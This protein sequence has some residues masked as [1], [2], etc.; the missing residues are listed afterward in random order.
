[1]QIVASRLKI[2]VAP[3][4]RVVVPEEQADDLRRDDLALNLIKRHWEVDPKQKTLFNRLRA[5]VRVMLFLVV[6]LGFAAFN[7]LWVPLKLEQESLVHSRADLAVEAG[8]YLEQKATPTT[9]TCAARDSL[10]ELVDVGVRDMI[11]PSTVESY[12]SIYTQNYESV[13]SSLHQGDV[14]QW[15]LFKHSKELGRMKVS[16]SSHLLCQHGRWTVA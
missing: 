13:C 12:V 9:E 4:I 5:N 6:L 8:R 15:A 2:L 3:Q 16:A 11:S 14:F 10:S 1:M 7:S